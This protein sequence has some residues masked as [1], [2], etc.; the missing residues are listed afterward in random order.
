[1]EVFRDVRHAVR[2]FRASPITSTVI[3]VTLALSIG[4]NTAL[5]SVADAVWLKA[6][7][8]PEASQLVRIH[9]RNGQFPRM[10]VSWADAGDWR[11]QED[12]FEGVSVLQ[13]GSVRVGTQSDGSR[14]GSPVRADWGARAGDHYRRRGG[15]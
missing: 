7:P 1:M 9:M 2:L 12:I 10:A 8:Y 14:V 4:V 15:C 5:F 13:P 3:V 11:M 6:V